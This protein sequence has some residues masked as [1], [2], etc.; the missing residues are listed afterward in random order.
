[1]WLLFC[2]KDANSSGW[3]QHRHLNLGNLASIIIWAKLMKNQTSSETVTL[4][5]NVWIS[6]I[7]HSVEVFPNM[8]QYSFTLDWY[9]QPGHKKV[10]WTSTSTLTLLQIQGKEKQGFFSCFRKEVYETTTLTSKDG[11][12]I[13]AISWIGESPRSPT[14]KGAA[15]RLGFQAPGVTPTWDIM[16]F[17][18]GKKWTKWNLWLNKCGENTHIDSEC[19]LSKAYFESRCWTKK[20]IA[21]MSKWQWCV[22]VLLKAY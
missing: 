13:Q 1:M 5:T 15:G 6:V 12:L 18:D 20:K 9:T 4:G 2:K 19:Y 10:L 22:M 3:Q 11:P 8:F 14:A 21:S 16:A 7:V 17:D